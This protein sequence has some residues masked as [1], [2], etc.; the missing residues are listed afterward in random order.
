MSFEWSRALETGNSTIDGEHKKLIAAANDLLEACKQGKAR[1][2]LDGFVEFLVNY[3]HTHFK[4]EEKL[5]IYH[6]FP[7]YKKHKEWHTAF[8]ASM[9]SLASKLKTSGTSVAILS[10]VNMQIAK[11]ISHIKNADTEIAKHIASKKS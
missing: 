5:Q 11:L 8:L 6:N 3:T 7:D 10:E 9:D 2:E 4:N 1:S